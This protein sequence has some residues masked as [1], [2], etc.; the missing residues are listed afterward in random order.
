ML[1]KIL[2][3]IFLNFSQKVKVSLKNVF[4]FWDFVRPEI[5]FG[6]FTSAGSLFFYNLKIPLLFLNTKQQNS[7]PKVSLFLH[8]LGL[9]IAPYPEDHHYSFEVV[10]IH[11]AV[12]L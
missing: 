1:L 2:L 9:Y 6:N 7:H 10:D 12:L 11:N 4:E 8:S 5:G 3:S